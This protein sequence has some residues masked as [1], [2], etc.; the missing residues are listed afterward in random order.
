VLC[1]CS[2]K[3]DFSE[4]GSVA[5]RAIEVVS[6]RERSDVAEPMKQARGFGDIPRLDQNAGD[7]SSKRSVNISSIDGIWTGPV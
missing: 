5:A 7:H 1:A 4:V 2:L 3:A 6:R